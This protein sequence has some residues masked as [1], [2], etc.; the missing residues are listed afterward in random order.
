MDP[1]ML[2]SILTY[3]V[4]VVVTAAY[5]F[6]INKNSTPSPV[7]DPKKP[8]TP[9]VLHDLL[10]ALLHSF[11]GAVSAPV[12]QPAVTPTTPDVS[13]TVPVTPV[14]PV[15]P[16][17]PILNQLLNALLG[18]L[19]SLGAQSPATSVVVVQPQAPKVVDVPK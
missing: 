14:A 7:V 17:H 8:V 4:P 12:S 18:K 15:A 9:N 13:P 11:L 19:L 6:F 10:D 2:T 16:A 1:A 3:L 5:H